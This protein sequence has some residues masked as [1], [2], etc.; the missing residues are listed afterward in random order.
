M[1]LFRKREDK[2]VDVDLHD[3]EV[4]SGNRLEHLP[5]WTQK[6]VAVVAI[7]WTVFQVYT[8]LFGLFPRN[9]SAHDN[10]FFWLV[11]LLYLF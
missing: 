1:K 3:L 2:I 8:A 5:G 4:E 6:I 9:D 7:V 10:T 11:S